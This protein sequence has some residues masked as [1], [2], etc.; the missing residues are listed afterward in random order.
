MA[1]M[2]E[3]AEKKKVGK[4]THYYQKIGVAIVDLE[5]TLSVGDHIEISGPNTNITQTVDSMQIE[6]ENVQQAKK[7]ASIG[8]KVTD[9]VKENDV[10]YKI[11]G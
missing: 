7:G 11:M 3:E 9:K 2:M 4:I 10:V 1:E 8:L 6:H 5:D